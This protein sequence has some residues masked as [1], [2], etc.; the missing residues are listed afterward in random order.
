VA[1]RF[2]LD[3]EAAREAADRAQSAGERLLDAHRA[4]VTV[5]DELHG[6]WGDDDVGKAFSN[7]YVGLADATRA[8][9]GV[10]GTNLSDVG[11]FVD[12]AVSDFTR[13]DEEN[14]RA[15]DGAYADNVKSWTSGS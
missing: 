4:L 7:E 2:E 3:E 8:N 15:V 14:A 1:D 10:L 11:D 13:T 12:S 6:C 9:T 5:L